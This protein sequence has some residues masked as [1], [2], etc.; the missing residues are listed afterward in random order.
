MNKKGFTTV[1]VVISFAL[2]VI[3]LISITAIVVNYRD[4]VTNEQ[5]MTQ[6]FDYKNS[7]TKIVYD[8][9]VIGEYQNI[10]RCTNDLFCVN[11][12][13]KDGTLV[14]LKR[15]V[16]DNDTTGLKR[17][18][19]L[20]YKGIKYMLPDSDLNQTVVSN[21]LNQDNYYSTINDFI[22]TTDD[23]NNLYSVT[24]PIY[25]RVLDYKLNINLRVN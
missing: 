15:I 13:K 16:V 7:L 2:V 19:Y 8:D 17:G 20:E 6:L 21:N 24:I 12:I 9:I 23:N 22:I 3:I 18:I 1:E 25:H 4:K 10:G 11:F 14:P 5:I